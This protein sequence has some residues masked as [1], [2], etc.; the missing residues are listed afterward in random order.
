MSV[1]VKLDV[2][3][4]DE[5]KTCGCVVTSDANN[6]RLFGSVVYHRSCRVTRYVRVD[7]CPVTRQRLVE[8]TAWVLEEVRD[9][10]L[11]ECLIVVAN[12]CESTVSGRSWVL[13]QT[14]TVTVRGSG[15]STEDNS[16]TLCVSVKRRPPTSRCGVSVLCGWNRETIR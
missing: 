13:L 9:L 16:A 2:F 10:L 11:V 6:I 4:V 15:S 1:C 5:L 12:L 3:V 14:V 8:A 7:D